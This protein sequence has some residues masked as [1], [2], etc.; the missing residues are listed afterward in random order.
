[1]SGLKNISPS[2]LSSW[3]EGFGEEFRRKVGIFRRGMAVRCFSD[4]SAISFTLKWTANQETPCSFWL[5]MC[6]FIRHHDLVKTLRDKLI[7]Q[8]ILR[9]MK[10]VSKSYP[11]PF[12]FRSFSHIAYDLIFTPLREAIFSKPDIC[13]YCGQFCSSLF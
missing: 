4:F 7:H 12:A 13:W 3:R 9:I 6:F 10:T 5:P 11:S 1:M 8:A 2:F